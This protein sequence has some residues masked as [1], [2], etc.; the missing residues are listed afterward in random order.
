MRDLP[1]LWAHQ[2]SAFKIK[3]QTFIKRAHLVGMAF[4]VAAATNMA[5]KGIV[6]SGAAVGNLRLFSREPKVKVLH[7]SWMAFFI[8]FVVWFNH[9]P[10]MAAIRETFS[11]SKEQVAALLIMN[12]ALTIPARVAVGMLVD[13]FGPRLM[14]AVL[15]AVSGLICL[16]FAFAQSFDVLAIA[17]FFLAFVGAGFVVGIRIISDWFPAKE[18]GYAQGIYAGLG[19]FGSAAAALTLPS[20]AIAFGG[21]EGWRWAIATTGIIAIAYSF[22]YYANVTDVP[23]GS[24]YFSPKKAGAMEVTS[25]GD[26][27][28]YC[29]MQAPLVLA[30][31]VLTWKLGPRELNL[32]PATTE[33]A[34]YGVLVVLYALQLLDTWRINRKIFEKPVADIHRYRFRQVA[35]LDIAYMITFGSEL[36][37]VSILPLL[38]KD[39]FGLSLSV[40]GFL[41]ASFGMTTFFAR[42]AGGWLSDR[43]GRR[44]VLVWCL[45]G[46]TVGYAAMSFMGPKTGVAFAVIATFLC[47]LFVNAGNGAVY[48]ML[49]MI[50][51]RLTGQIAGMV[52][53]FGNVGGV[54]FLAIYSILDI[55]TFFMV[56][57]C[58]GLFGLALIYMLIDEPR[59]QIAEE[60]PD[61]SIAMIDV[62]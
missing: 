4:A 24:T 52:G 26:F 11:L 40:A 33:L 55:G 6:M 49:P 15:L 41:G 50:K 5:T 39:V 27:V 44:R 46:T 28:L 51:R 35:V 62:R 14:Y 17:R 12:V 53:A 58:A 38:F 16:V 57:S 23:K 61:G 54:L 30:L 13:K 7:L 42:P 3:A 31:G 10:L 29:L 21:P 56:A 48:A 18:T 59:G 1:H 43:F 36:A 22:I 25:R 45:A 60:M 20:L 2:K 9:A 8:S 34:V 47:S 19:N 37:V 32:I